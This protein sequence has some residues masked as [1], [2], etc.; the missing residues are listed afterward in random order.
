[1]N[2]SNKAEVWLRGPLPGI[3]PALQPVAQALLQ[4][5]EELNEAMENF[6]DK[7]GRAHV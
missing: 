1:M 7:I 2:A 5:R 3:L 4:A 6:E